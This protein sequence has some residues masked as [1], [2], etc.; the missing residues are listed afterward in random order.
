MST[1]GKDILIGWQ[2]RWKLLLGLEI[3]LYALGPA[4]FFYFLGFNWPWVLGIFI[5]VLLILVFLKKPWQVT[6]D[7]LS[8]YIDQKLQSVEYSTGLLLQ[9]IEELS[10]LAQLQSMKVVK[11]LKSEN[12]TM[13]P[14]KGLKMAIMVAASLVL[15]GFLISKSGL[16]DRFGTINSG[17]PEKEMIDFRPADSLA[18][19]VIPPKL[20]SQEVIISYPS[21]TGMKSTNSSN[22]N[23][24]A[25]EGSRL[26]WKIKFDAEVD[27]VLLESNV[28]NQSMKFVDGAYVKST[29]LTEPGFYNFRFTDRLGGTYVSEL[30]ALEVTQDQ[31]P[32]LE[33]QGLKQFESF[34]YSE[35]KMIRFN[36][37]IKDDYGIADAAI[38][39]TVSKGS[40]ESVKFREE[41]L[42]FDTKSSSGSKNLE[43]SKKLDLDVLKME[44]GDEL[45]FYVETHDTKRPKA[46]ISR[47]E[48]FFAVI[49]DT[50]SGQFAV[51]GTMGADLMPDYFRSQ[52][53]LIIDTEKLITQKSKLTEY[54]FNSTSN[55]LGFDQKALRLKYGE[56]MGDEA[57]SGI[58]GAQPEVE[59]STDP[60]DPLAEFT[61]D[62]DGDNEHNLVDHDHDEGV[63]EKKAED[64][65]HDYLHDHDNPEESTL[66]TQSLRSMLQ[67]AMA[68]MWD[69]ELHLRLYSPDK[70]LPYQYKA[71]KLIQEIKNSARIYVH[72]IG[73]DPPPIKEEV[74][75]TGDI[76]DVKTFQKKAEIGKSEEY[77]NMRKAVERIEQLLEARLS[78]TS[79]DKALFER[80]GNELAIKAIEE[81]GKYLNALQGLKWLTE[82]V[83]RSKERLLEVQRGLLSALPKPEPNPTKEDLFDSEI[84]ALLLKELETYE[85]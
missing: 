60:D 18:R 71:L 52:R 12:K 50:V 14:K 39:A 78:G 20:E 27:S 72:R 79:E 37:L 75:L 76:A 58:Q 3:F 65:L 13:L 82:D 69:A 32:S 81:P 11:S 77:S 51:E 31:P 44:P 67:Q 42:A 70:S 16:T 4:M 55:E 84:N 63:E 85:R 40:G 57:D 5:S 23:I 36:T 43:L 30:Y 49:K 26:S 22:M 24:K 45:Y 64:P 80:A 62:H 66:F 54:E 21:Y 47:S 9:P 7:K 53:Q 68:E 10:S 1:S 73:F 48:T 28:G 19:E 34:E 46:N 17:T 83:E 74:R 6:L 25:L 38:I 33:I 2:K 59:E 15:L 56:F 35:P 29:T 8:T 61:H 41:K